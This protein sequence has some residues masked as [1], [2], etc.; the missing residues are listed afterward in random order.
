MACTKCGKNSCGCDKAVSKR[1]PVG[2][3][4]R[5][6]RDGRIG[7]SG[8]AGRVPYIAT[9]SNDGEIITLADTQVTYQQLNILANGGGVGT[10]FLST[11]DSGNLSWV[12]GGG[13]GSIG[14]SISNT[15]V[16]FGSGADTITGSNDFIY[17]SG[18][19]SNFSSTGTSS[20]W[21]NVQSIIGS[22]G[23][24]AGF[25]LNNT[26]AGGKRYN[27][28]ST[29]NSSGIGGGRFSIGDATSGENRFE[30]N[31][32]GEIT[33]PNLGGSGI[34]VV[35]VDNTGK[36]SYT[37]K[38]ITGTGTVG[39][40]PKIST[41]SGGNI[42]TLVDSY[43][44]EN[45]GGY[46]YKTNVVV[47]TT[48]DGYFSIDS[49]GAYIGVNAI[50]G[51]AGTYTSYIS[52][53]LAN[54]NAFY[55]ENRHV[56]T[57]GLINYTT[58]GVLVAPSTV[59]ILD[60]SSRLI[61]SATTD[62][63]LAALSTAGQGVNSGYVLRTNGAG[64]LSWVAM[65]GG[66]GITSLSAIG[67]T[68]NADG[69]TIT[70]SVLNLEPASASFG[71]VTTTGTQTFA[72]NKTHNGSQTF[73]ADIGGT[74]WTIAQATGRIILDNNT[75]SSD[76]SGALTAVSF[77]GA[78]T[79]NA[80]TATALATARTIN[81]TSFD[82][83]ANITVTAAAGTL[84][85]TT[86]NATVVSSSLTSHGTITS[87]G[88]GTGAVV[89]GVTMT[90]GSDASYDIYYR[91]ASGILTRLANG[92]TGQVLTATTSNAPSWGTASGGSLTVGTT[93]ISSG[94]TTR[95]LYDNAGVL[96][97][98]TITGTG[99]V[100]AMQTSPTFITDIT[101]PL[102]IGGT[103][104]GSNILYKSTSGTGTSTA[105]A[106]QFVGGTNGGTI[107]ATY[108]NDGKVNFGSTAAGA[109]TRS[110]GTITNFRVQTSTSTFDVGTVSGDGAIWFNTATPSTTN[111]I[112]SSSGLNL[113]LNC[114]SG[115]S[116][117]FRVG[118]SVV[119][120]FGT[121]G[122]VV[123]FTALAISSLAQ[124]VYKWTTPASTG[125]TAGSETIG[126]DFDMSTNT[127]QHASNTTIA[128]N[129]DFKIKARTHRFASATGTITDGATVWITGAPIAGTNATYTNTHGLYIAA[130]ASVVSATNSYGL[131]VNA[132]TG[133]TNN[134][135]A[136]FLGGAVLFGSTARLKGYT[137]ATLPT[138]VVGDTAY[139]TDL[140]APTF[141]ATAV[142][143]GAITGTVFF[144][145]T[146]WKS[147]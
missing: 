46:F 137:V 75:I 106:H 138:G 54:G 92:T 94:A 59:M 55:T 64:V 28:I 146:N 22:D 70:G 47:G 68:P 67:S 135:A 142:G 139:V 33:I 48:M 141:L 20:G 124:S 100:V 130:S 9:I 15:Q 109:I 37:S 99:T 131:T 3:Q 79:G 122:S 44:S 71:G 10:R 63:Q 115:S 86:L 19:L 132:Q 74:K 134:Y 107:Y 83:T 147:Q 49:Q 112:I 17:S 96:G 127:I 36:M 72:G 12:S 6:G 89:G 66:G 14:G 69:A 45:Q 121:N 21:G 143:G 113:N 125:Q 95:I 51:V 97:E 65:S 60:A 93:T 27:I 110:G 29:S 87:G 5:P 56:F 30:I 53:N 11:D 117:S 133:A 2:P 8:T 73:G 105:I 114:D 102:I 23:S 144:D 128:T 16:A 35:G 129:G 34:G 1:G 32:A 88:L 118:G 90:L 52:S 108:H 104:V 24:E 57:G 43:T 145:G 80:S 26:G 84:T 78:L 40:I 101:T 7:G 39:Y 41:I 76:G 136:Q 98:Y 116:M 81:G 42:L 140:L 126:F 91:N 111:Y 38:G 31:S 50:P 18:T 119:Q 4:G 82:G 103:A 85:G 120:T 25:S 13:G 61:S 123:Q 77:I 62:T 58:T